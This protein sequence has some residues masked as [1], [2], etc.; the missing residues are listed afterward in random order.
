MPREMLLALEGLVEPFLVKWTEHMNRAGYLL[1]T[2]AKK[3]D[4]ILSYQGFLQPLWTELR[5]RRDLGDFASLLRRQDGWAE[6]VLA[7]SQRHRFRGV[8]AEMFLGCFKT[9]VHSVEDLL[10][11]MNAPADRTLAA[12]DI[13]RRYADALDTLLIGHWTALSQQEALARLDASNR[14]LTL[15]KN[16][17]ENIF[18]TTSDLVLVTDARGRVEE[19]NKAARFFLG[20]PSPDHT[21]VWE[22]LDLKGGTMAEVLALYPPDAAHEIGIRDG[23]VFLEM[24]IAPFS[25][26]SLASS[27]YLFLLTD[28]TGHVRYRV[29]LEENVRA[30][31]AE[32]EQ[33][34]ARLEEMNITLRNVLSSIESERKESQRSIAHAVETTLLPTLK[35]VQ[36]ADDPAVRRGYA[37]LLS[38]QLMRL[39]DDSGGGDARLLSLTPTEFKIC[40]FIQSGSRTK[41]IAEALNL[42]VETVQSHRKNIRRKLSLSGKDVNLFTFLKAS[43]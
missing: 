7:M 38:D 5:A 31:T 1:L 39:Y 18:A 16:K 4:C 37:G 28:I 26:V 3:E 33:K 10:H 42:S 14:Q 34:T 12:T 29:T 23:T 19:V 35:Y 15:Q 30:R 2:T 21:T 22:I 36:S 41:D 43:G 9:L 20:E 24:R 8:T 11:E 32:L 25:S 27:N 13:L 17:F 40:Q 6:D